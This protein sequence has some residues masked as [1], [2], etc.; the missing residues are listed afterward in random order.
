MATGV[1]NRV[2]PTRDPGRLGMEAAMKVASSLVAIRPGKLADAGVTP[3]LE[4]VAEAGGF[5]HAQHAILWVLRQAADRN[6]MP[7]ATEDR[8]PQP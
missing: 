1:S 2:P 5:T 3:Y 6:I 8:P 7:A 4:R